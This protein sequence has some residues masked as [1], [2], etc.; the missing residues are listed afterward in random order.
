[1]CRIYRSTA[2]Q[3]FLVAG[4]YQLTSVLGLNQF[5]TNNTLAET[6]PVVFSTFGQI[7][8]LFFGIAYL[9]LTKRFTH[10][11]LVVGLFS[12]T[13]FLYFGAW[14]YWLL[15][16]PEKLDHLAGESM[17]Q[18]SFFASYGFANLLLGGFCALVAINTLKGRY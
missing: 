3:G 17:L 7:L 10:A 15:N 5:F 16:F 9:W 1:M 6:D 13:N 4:I 11:P 18:F 2:T 12:L 8:L 14:L